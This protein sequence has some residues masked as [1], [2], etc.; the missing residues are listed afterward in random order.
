MGQSDGP[1]LSEEEPPECEKYETQHCGDL[2]ASEQVV[3]QL[4]EDAQMQRE[5]LEELRRSSQAVQNESV[6]QPSMDRRDVP[7]LSEEPQ[8]LGRHR[9]Q[10]DCPRTRRLETAA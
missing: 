9:G 4:R 3:R 8:P 6:I 2:T 5:E 1:L 7:S 10:V